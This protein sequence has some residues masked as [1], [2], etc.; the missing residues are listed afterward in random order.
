MSRTDPQFNLR[1]PEELR[2]KV[3][4]SAKANGRSSTAEILSRLELSY[5]DGTTSDQDLMP[6]D[7]AKELSEIA[8]QS[9]PGIVKKRI[10]KAI[11]QAVKFGHG[12]AAVELGDLGLESIPGADLEALHDAFSEM[13]RDAGYKFE[14]DGGNSLWIVFE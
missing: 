7:K 8:R 1:I 14:W 5:L 6:A 11:N 10:L 9:I 12:S 4:A 13:L 2:D 3:M